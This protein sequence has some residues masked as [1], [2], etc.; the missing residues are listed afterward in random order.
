M[1]TIWSSLPDGLLSGLTGLDT[2]PAVHGNT[3]DPLPLTVTVEKV[4]TDQARAEVLAGAP[5]AVAFKATVANGSL[6]GGATTLGVAAGSVEGTPVTV[7]R[8]SGTTESVTVDIDLS[9][10]P[11]L[12]TNHSGLR[13]REGDL[14]PAGGRSCRRWA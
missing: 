1:T 3:V 2:A 5:L 12:P 4:G 6:A 9:T 10:Q 8:T 14:G 7:T 11:T 13:V